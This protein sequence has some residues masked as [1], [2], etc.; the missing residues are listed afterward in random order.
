MSDCLVVMSDC[1][2]MVNS[3]GQLIQA[4]QKTTKSFLKHSFSNRFITENFTYLIAAPNE[5][6][7]PT[8]S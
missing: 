2:G 6:N 5:F 4:F 7:R 1:F 3:V 8:N